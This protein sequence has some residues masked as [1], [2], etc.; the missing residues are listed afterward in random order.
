M[1]WLR[2]LF[3]LPLGVVFFVLLLVTLVLLQVSAM[4]LN[5]DF[6]TEE[7]RDAEV[8]DFVLDDL[9]T[10]FVDEARAK[11]ADEFNSTF[12]TELEENPFV[13][14]SLT[15]PQIVSSVRRAVPPDWIQGIVE[16]S[17][18][19]IF[20]YLTAERDEFSVTIRA[21]ERAVV[22]VDEIK[23]LLRQ[24]DAYNLLYEEVVTPAIEEATKK[25]RKAD[26]TLDLESFSSELPLSIDVDDA[27]ILQAIQEVAPPNWVRRQVEDALDAVTPYFLESADGFRVHVQLDDRVTIAQAE[28]R[29]LLRST[30]AYELLYSEVIEPRVLEQI[31]DSVDLPFGI[32]VSEDEIVDALRRTAPPSWVREQVDRVVEDVTPWLVGQTDSFETVIDLSDNKLQ[33]RDIIVEL[34]DSR[35]RETI[36]QRLPECGNAQ[37]ATALNALRSRELPNCIPP[38]FPVGELVQ[39]VGVDAADLVTRLVLAPL[40]NDIRF[41]DTQIRLSLTIAGAEETLERLDEVRDIL[42]DGFVYTEADL[43]S[44][45]LKGG[46]GQDGLDALDEVRGFLGDGFTYTSG[47]IQEFRPLFGAKPNTDVVSGLND[48]R[49]Y[50]SLARTFRWVV[51]LPMLLLLVVIGFLGG[52]GWSGR[53]TYASAV[54]VISTGII[55]V[56]SGPVYENV[57]REL[58]EDGRSEALDQAKLDETQYPATATLAANK[59]FDMLVSIADRFADGVSDL[60]RNL[61]VVGI[62]AFAAAVFWSSIMGLT[63]R[64]RPTRDSELGK[65]D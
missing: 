60:A 54:L 30:D 40:P 31:G 58:I 29:E 38:Q 49:D 35:L 14:A 11:D 53:V 50:F 8:Y 33:A 64:L 43:R 2:R 6:Y 62:I 13:T 22:L 23:N 5:P 57:A 61:F 63:H 46:L 45:L 4:F 42:R 39:R 48:V 34:V 56:A 26:D 44:D 7:L 10:T 51:W 65:W 20:N 24:A 21:G 17:F 19:P 3:T 41:T 16:Q 52:R 32:T 12:N 59:G 9:L 15:T 55:L 28:V 36:E 25:H 18:D 1:I 27:R 47:D 37:L